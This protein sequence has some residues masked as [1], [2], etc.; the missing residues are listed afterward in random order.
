MQIDEDRLR[1]DML[2]NGSF[3]RVET[4][5]G[6]G[7]TVLLG[8]DA[9]RE[10]RE[11]LVAILESLDIDVRIDA[12]GNVAGRWAPD[13]CDPDRA[14]VAMGSHL[15]SVPEGGIFDGPLGVY[16][17]VEAVRA[18]Q[19]AGIEPERP[20]EVVSFTEEEGQRFDVGLLGS[21][22]ATGERSVSEALSLADDAGTTL[23]DHL[24]GIGFHG[25]GLVDASEWDAWLELH[26]EQATQLERAG[27]PVGVVSAITGITNCVV[28]IEG[29][30]NHAGGTRMDERTDALVA[31]SAFAE[32]VERIA[33]EVSVTESEAAVATV[34]SLSVAP[35][36]RNVVPGSVRLTI[37]VRDVDRA[38]MD[39]VVDKAR[40]SLA[41][42]DRERGTESTLTRYRTVL[43]TPMSERCRA[44][45]TDAADRHGIEHLE[46][47]SGGGHDTM[48]VASVT[49]AGL[50]FAP[51]KDGISHSPREWTDWEDC[52][53]A[54]QVLADAAARL[55]G[56]TP[57]DGA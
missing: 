6:H 40:S 8:S 15:D 10:A 4:E 23:R 16:A 55:A 9:D 26:V 42:I 41:R 29:E 43:P 22:V 33:R 17:A 56:A 39:E 53:R 31:A 5:E 48:A 12:V 1:E 21:S 36:A 52:A 13:G 34:G 45:L 47:P 57:D 44:A 35:N 19:D 2:A 51:S 18:M 46:L 20:I 30:A 24:E 3:G 54:A 11:R 28:E 32:D 7:R 38:V 49:D 50:L 25:E 14:P 37:D 27:V